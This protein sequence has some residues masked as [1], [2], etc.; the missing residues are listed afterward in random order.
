MGY[1]AL[2]RV[3]RPQQFA[4][5]VGQQ[6]ITQTLKNA[7]AAKQTSHA[8][9]FT[10]PR[11][12]GKT[13][14]AKI[15]AKA[16]NCHFQKDG[17]PCNQCDTCQAI[18]EGRLN[19]V[20]EIDAASNNSVDE[21]RDIREKVKY[22][23]TQADYKI[24]IIDEVHMLSTGAFNALLKTLEEPPANVIFILATTEPYKI[25]ATII[26]R[27]Q[28]FDFHRINDQTLIKRM[29][30]ILKQEKVT[31]DPA[32]LEVIAKAAAGGMRDA[33]SMLDQVLSF[34]N[35]QATLKD[36]LLVTG[37]VAQ[38]Q[39]A[40]YLKAVF[41]QQAAPAF[42]QLQ[43]LLADGKDP[44]Q[45]FEGLIDY[46]RQLLLQQ[47]VFKDQKGKA[48]E[49]LV[50]LAKQIPTK[51]IYQALDILSQEQQAMR[52]ATHQAVYLDVA[53]VKL[54][55]LKPNNRSTATAPAEAEITKLQTEVTALKKQLDQLVQRPMPVENQ[56]RE[57]KKV[58][59]TKQTKIH[60]NLKEIY[61]VLGSA[62]R[63]SLDELKDVWQDLM[64]K[65]SVTQR[66]IMNVSQP[67][68]ASQTAAVISFQYAF[69]FEKA[70]ENQHLR[71]QLVTDLAVLLGRQVKLTFLPQEQ[72]PQIRQN[73]LREYQHDKE[74]PT[75]TVTKKVASAKDPQ[76]L[77]AQKI[78]GK[79]AEKLVEF[80][81]D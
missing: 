41:S 59:V 31:F 79:A 39:L 64:A 32:A 34:G 45:L 73:Y 49:E 22:A 77:T 48:K 27:T 58:S 38:E 81:D 29:E 43:Q 75:K 36:A 8:Y 76:A 72:W 53:T 6:L 15:F 10:G 63:E 23:P 42:Q 19:D 47:T 12:T 24:Y 20:I 3:W 11:G 40:A 62:S 70:V 52:F 16:I 5:L 44:N 56:V 9:L 68:A 25:P 33:L 66:A 18:T 78:W 51:V 71:T 60:P 80:K 37:S 54:C 67:V 4:D 7:I 28:R 13:S 30:Y 1:R 57:P 69:L 2:Y 35:H 21:I 74:Q 17:E 14:A 65:L 55:Q 26:S 50:S 46:C 61:A